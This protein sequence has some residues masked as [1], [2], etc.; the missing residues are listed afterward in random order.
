[1]YYIYIW[2]SYRVEMY[3]CRRQPHNWSGVTE[4]STAGIT[5]TQCEAYRLTKRGQEHEMVS[6]PEYDAIPT[7]EGEQVHRQQDNPNKTT[8]SPVATLQETGG[9]MEEA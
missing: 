4:L 9:N 1:M 8:P 2:I 5:T 3:V 6:E 7:F